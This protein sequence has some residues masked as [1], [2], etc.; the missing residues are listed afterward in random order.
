MKGAFIRDLAYHVDALFFGLV[1]YISMEKGPL[2]QRYGDGWAR[3]VVV[4]TSVFRPEPSRQAWRM[5]AGIL[6]G[7]L[8]WAATGIIQLILK[9]T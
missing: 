5:I 3:T 2:R 9:V 1:G 4:K 8:L 7:S 6:M